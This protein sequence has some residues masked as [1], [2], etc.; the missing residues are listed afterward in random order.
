MN[1]VCAVI[2]MAGSI[3]CLSLAESVELRHGSVLA[4]RSCLIPELVRQ[5]REVLGNP[6]ERR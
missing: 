2:V 4:N 6:A 3:S 1:C 5:R